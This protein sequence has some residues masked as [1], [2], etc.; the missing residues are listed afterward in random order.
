[1]GCF[2]ENL[3]DKEKR[4]FEKFHQMT[5]DKNKDELWKIYLWFID[6]SQCW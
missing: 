5:K 3:S 6:C 1:M 2:N 4:I